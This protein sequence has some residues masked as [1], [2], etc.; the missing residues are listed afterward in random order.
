MSLIKLGF[1][2]HA[3]DGR[4][5]LPAGAELTTEALEGL[6]AARPE[7]SSQAV[8]LLEYGTIRQDILAF[9][10]M[11]PYRVIFEDPVRKAGLLEVMNKVRLLPPILESLSYFKAHDHYTY[12]H[13]LIVFAM[14]TLLA[15]DLV[16]DYQD[17]MQEAMAGPSHDFGKI[18]VPLGILKKTDAL[19]RT[20][21]GILEHHASAG[22]VLLSY[23]LGDSQ[24]LAAHVAKEHHERRDGS[25]YPLG[26]LLADSMVEIIAAADIYDALISPRPYRPRAYD[27]RTALE[28]LTE[29]A[30][31]G[32]LSWE[33]LQALVA[34]NRKG[35]PHHS[36][37]AVS[38]EKRGVPPE[39]NLYGVILD[40][41]PPPRVR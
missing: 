26:I 9:M 16:Q 24:G 18:A 41:L 21:R 37:C 29:L 20:E 14:S 31:Q 32:K 30:G 25:G 28:E 22:F 7:G 1:P 19:S 8:P 13:I 11:E 10:E 35:K 15:Q 27:N 23:Y 2:V 33:V 40:D 38:L 3:M 34:Y 5:L 4:L 39:D 12:R 6:I 36:A 17:L